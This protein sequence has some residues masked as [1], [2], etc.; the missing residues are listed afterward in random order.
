MTIDRKW[1]PILKMIRGKFRLYF[2]GIDGCYSSIEAVISEGVVNHRTADG[3]VNN[4]DGEVDLMIWKNPSG[5]RN[6]EVARGNGYDPNLR[7]R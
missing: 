6:L 4:Y 7:P 2:R 1:V 5:S 3:V